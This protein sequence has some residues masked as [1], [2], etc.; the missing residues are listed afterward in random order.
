[1]YDLPFGRN[2]WMG[3]GMNRILDAIVGGW[4][5]N[6]LLTL[7]SGQPTPLGLANGS[8]ADGTQRPN[9]TC[10]PRTRLSLHDLAF[11]TDPSASYYNGACFGVP[12]DQVPGNA[13]RFSAN[14]RGQGIRNTDMGFF[15]D[16][17]IREGMKVELRAEFFNLT[18]STRFRIPDSL[19]G[20]TNFGRVTRQAN[21]PRLGQ[22]A[23]RFEF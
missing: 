2:R 7:Q 20:D 17:T 12:D 8:I 23:V 11:S 9:I 10:S 21:S 18:N 5:L 19:L 1:V 3:G 14:A 6:A 4:S 16:F 22:I 13:P 15:K